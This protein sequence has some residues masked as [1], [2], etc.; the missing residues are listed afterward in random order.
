MQTKTITNRLTTSWQLWALLLALSFGGIGFGATAF[1]FSLPSNPRCDRFFLIF[2]SA[3][4]R[5]YCA[6][7]QAEKETVEGL[8]KAI[9]LVEEL[10][11][12][13]PLR[14]EINR[15][16]TEWSKE[17]LLIGDEKFQAGNLDEAINIANKI[18]PN[19]AGKDEVQAKI[20][21]WRSIWE[22]AKNIEVDVEKELRQGQWN[23]AFL[24][25]TKFLNLSNEYW[26]TTK[27]EE[28]VKKINL[29][30][31]ESK[32]LDGA[33]S[34][35]NRKGISN[36]LQAISLAKKIDPSSYSYDQAQEIIKSAQEEIVEYAQNLLDRQ[37]W[38]QLAELA[39]QIPD[40]LQDLKKQA[41]DWN[42]IA[43]AGKNAELGTMTGLELAI[44]D[45]NS[46]DSTNPL[47]QETQAL[48]KNWQL[49][50]ENL[51]YLTE[52]RS[53]ASPGNLTDLNQAI[54]KARL[55]SSDNPLYR[56]AQ[57]EINKW[58]REIEVMEDQPILDSAREKASANNIQAWQEAINQ[59]A[60]IKSNRALYSEAQNLISKWRRSIE[61]QEDQ[62]F[63]S[64][65]ISLAE[66]GSYQEAINAASQIKPNR[67][68]YPE[69]QS[70]IRSWRRQIKAQGDLQQA[71]SIA[72][73]NSPEALLKA[74]SIAR[75]IPSSTDVK[76]QSRLA[77]N[78]WSEQMLS[79][80]RRNAETGINTSVQEAITIADMI[81]YGTLAY[82]VARQEIS[83]WQEQLK[84]ALVVPPS[85]PVQEA[86]YFS[87]ESI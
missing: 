33:Y 69:A 40:D 19:L 48:I 4:S 9:A 77:I 61:T 11:D 53:I 55:I 21:K 18:P 26:Q 32:Q 1:L 3:T 27:Y 6:Q 31:E 35:L 62:P 59:A 75:A 13:H 83:K 86:N 5:I 58:Q 66:S 81:P 79:I 57:R 67:A 56:E 43:T 84:P 71:F 39:N 22:N 70:K 23:K 60:Q 52:A 28:T 7:L 74:I 2:S 41:Q 44:V 85:T 38:S 8:L 24:I 50:K 16:V 80:A 47:Y 42:L 20:D 87:D 34:A 78:R 45:A 73:A 30:K 46:I 63:L 82:P 17:I 72:Q 12:D 36:L 51:T 68:L 14:A 54:V 37:R 76:E 10:P 49:E 65:A 25:A 29:A 64:Q 15:Y